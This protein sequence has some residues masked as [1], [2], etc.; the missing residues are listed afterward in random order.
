MTK[1]E[2]L[3]Q[4]ILDELAGVVATLQSTEDPDNLTGEQL[5]DMLTD[6]QDAAGEMEDWYEEIVGKEDR[7]EDSA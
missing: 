6:L 5:W 1:Y 7:G 3:K 4:E 2:Q